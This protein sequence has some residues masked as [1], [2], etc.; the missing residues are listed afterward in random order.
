MPSEN[1]LALKKQQTADLTEELKSASTLVIADHRGLSVEEDTEMRAALRQAGVT[2]R[3][4]KNTMLRLAAQHASIENMDDLFVGPSAIAY[5]VDDPIA[6]A[7]VLK[8]FADRF[9]KLEIKGGAMDG[10]RVDMARIMQLATIPDVEVLYAR[11]VGGLVSPISGLAML[12]DAIRNKVEEAGAETAAAVV[13][14][15][16]AAQADDADASEEN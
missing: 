7:K 8:Q 5:S 3:V 14:E 9:D 15:S 4:V 11:V 6:P 1:V 2:Y 16:N 13:V 10:E 12:L